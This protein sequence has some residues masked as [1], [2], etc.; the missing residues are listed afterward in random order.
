MFQ[1]GQELPLVMQ[2]GSNARMSFKD[3]LPAPMVWPRATKFDMVTRFR[4]DAPV[5]KGF[6]KTPT[7]VHRE[8]P[9]WR[10]ASI[11][12]STTPPGCGRPCGHVKQGGG[13]HMTKP[14]WSKPHTHSTP[15]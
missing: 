10:K 1:G 5:T 9:K 3:T 6:L 12:G 13:A 7:Y 4:M 15:N 14:G 8:Q 11:T 2:R